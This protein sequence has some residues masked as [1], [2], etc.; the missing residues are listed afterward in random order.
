MTKTRDWRDDS[1][2][3]AC[4]QKTWLPQKDKNKNFTIIDNAS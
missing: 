1:K 3:F 2:T 4:Q